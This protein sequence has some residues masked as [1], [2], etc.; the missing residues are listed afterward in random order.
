MEIVL[1]TGLDRAKFGMVESELKSIYGQPDKVVPTEEDGIDCQYYKEK[2]TFRFYKDHGGKLGWIETENPRV[3]LFGAE[4]IGKNRAS[5]IAILAR[6]GHD[7][8]ESEEYETFD[9]IFYEHTCLELE[10]EKTL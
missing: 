5:V 1:G 3:L 2:A 4:V 7:K 6:N 8:Y 10:N 9:T